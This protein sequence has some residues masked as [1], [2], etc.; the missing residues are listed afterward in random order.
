[1]LFSVL[2]QL[3]IILALSLN[4]FQAHASHDDYCFGAFSLYYKL[5]T[6]CILEFHSHHDY[7]LPL[8]IAPYCFTGRKEGELTRS[9]VLFFKRESFVTLHVMMFSCNRK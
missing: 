7:L 5:T 3:A 4:F 2:L 8:S 1:L 6:L 9:K